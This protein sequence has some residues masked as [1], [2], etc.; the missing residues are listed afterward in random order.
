MGYQTEGA[1]T[2]ADSGNSR[3][4]NSVISFANLLLKK[5]EENFKQRELEFSQRHSSSAKVQKPTIEAP[6]FQEPESKEI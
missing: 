6:T 1:L 3:K 4:S 2:A 5:H